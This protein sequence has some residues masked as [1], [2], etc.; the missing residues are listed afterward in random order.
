MAGEEGYI[1]I[2]EEFLSNTEQTLRTMTFAEQAND[3]A[4]LKRAA[5]MLQ[6]GSGSLGAT[7]LALLCREFQTRLAAGALRNERLDIMA[8]MAAEFAVV[9]RALLELS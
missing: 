5:H 8:R 1:S 7:Q 2:R 6:G 9:H 4:A 3:T